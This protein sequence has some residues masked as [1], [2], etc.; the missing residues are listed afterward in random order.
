[1]VLAFYVSG[2]AK[3]VIEAINKISSMFYGPVLA[4]FL[5]AILTKKVKAS[6][7]NIGLITG[8]L[9]NLILWLFFKNVFW[10]WWNLIGCAVTTAVALLLSVFNPAVAENIESKEKIFFASPRVT[11]ILL[12]F[13][14]MIVVFSYLLPHFF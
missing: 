14:L 9:V 5:M 1:M 2:I 3:T 13:F 12:L 4:V 8:V 10:F 6:S 7:V 11:V